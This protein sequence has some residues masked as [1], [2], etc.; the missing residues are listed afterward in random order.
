MKT[1]AKTAI[2][3]SFDLIGLEVRRKGPKKEEWEMEDGSLVLPKI[4][5]Q[6]LFRQ[7]IPLRL[8]SS[9]GPLVLLGSPGEVEFLCSGFAA[10]GRE[11]RGISWD[12]ESQTDI[13]SVPQETL[14]VLCKLPKSERHWR[15]VKQLKQQFGSRLIGI[16][17]LV[18]PFTTLQQGQSLLEYAVDSFGEIVPLYL[19]DRYF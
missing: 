3:K 5:N 2:K 18:L 7:M 15:I 11:V 13:T 17:E 10:A 1:I 16:Q 19:G 14:V 9:T 8:Q 4:W 6:P 12:W